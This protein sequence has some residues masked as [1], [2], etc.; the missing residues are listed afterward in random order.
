[1]KS[2]KFTNHVFPYKKD[3]LS[4]IMTDGFA[5][6]FGGATGKKL[7]FKPFLEAVTSFSH[8]D[9][10]EQKIKLSGVFDTWKS[11]YEQVDDVLVL[12]FKV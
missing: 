7:K 1:G 10:Q 4:Y 12:G 6:Q 2:I 5:D 9:I 8:L 11:G 3:D